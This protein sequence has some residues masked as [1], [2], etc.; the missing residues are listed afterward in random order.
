M[1]RFIKT[2][3]IAVLLLVLAGGLGAWRWRAGYD[4]KVLFNTAVVTHGDLVTTISATG[5]IEPVEVV[6]VGAQVAGLVSSFG[7]DKNGK[8]IGYGSIVEEG[9]LLAKIDESLY[10]AE[11]ALA[12]AQ[13]DQAK[14]GEVRA[15]AD[16]DQMKAKAVQTEAD[17]K[18]AQEL[19]RAQ[20]LA[21]AD[22][23]SYKA[24]YEVAKAS[25]AVGEAAIT[26]A[27]AAT[28]QAEATLK[29]AQRNLDFCTI[30]SPVKGVIIDRRVNVGQ[31]VVASF[32]APSLFLIAK[33]LTKMEVWASVNEAD[34]GKLKIDMPVNFSCDSFPNETFHGNISQIRYNATMNQNVVLYTVIITTDN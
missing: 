12:R 17:W 13:V 1:K 6:D 22:Y 29:K 27:K 3:L 2:P 10:A 21:G 5:T 4:H 32:N 18:R 31:T 19:G 30:K 20:L 33:D 24:N 34:I 26:Q 7:Q 23:D 8:M 9:T 11:F 14:A 16:L 15:A 28:L 25:V